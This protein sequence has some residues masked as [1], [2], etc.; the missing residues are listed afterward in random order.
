MGLVSLGFPQGSQPQFTRWISMLYSNIVVTY[1][2]IV[3]F[4]DTG[5]PSSAPSVTRPIK[6]SWRKVVLTDWHHNGL[7]LQSSAIS[8][9]KHHPSTI[10]GGFPRLLSSDNTGRYL[11][12][13]LPYA[14]TER[15]KTHTDASVVQTIVALLGCFGR[16]ICC[17]QEVIGNLF[18]TLQYTLHLITCK[19]TAATV[20]PARAVHILPWLDSILWKCNLITLK[21]MALRGSTHLSS[22]CQVSAE[23]RKWWPTPRRC[24]HVSSCPPPSSY[25]RNENKLA[26]SAKSM[27]SLVC[28]LHFV[29]HHFW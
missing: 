2:N 17:L 28:S 11:V 3:P 18:I 6:S 5:K 26:K 13:W 21:F 22:H 12:T 19:A 24:S 8:T 25:L 29:F 16:A 7:E 15:S 23:S 4:G 20:Q 1:G 27:K 9:Q 10:S 14:A